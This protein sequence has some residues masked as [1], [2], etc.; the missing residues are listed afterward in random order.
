[1]HVRHTDRDFD[2]Y[3]LNKH[4]IGHGYALDVVLISLPG[5]ES[6]CTGG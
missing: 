6:G 1:M 3:V 5:H 4:A 2:V